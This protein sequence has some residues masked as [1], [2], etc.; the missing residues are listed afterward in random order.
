MLLPMRPRTRAVALAVAF[1]CV[2]LLSA[3][4]LAL[5][6][7]GYAG[8]RDAGPDAN[9]TSGDT[10]THPIGKHD[11]GSGHEAGRGDD[12]GRDATTTP[13][14]GHD[15]SMAM[16]D[17]FVDKDT[18]VVPH[19]AGHDAFVGPCD[20]DFV[21]AIPGT[22]TYMV[23][24]EAGVDTAVMQVN[25]GDLLVAIAYSGQGATTALSTAP[26]M[27]LTV[28]DTAGSVFHTG[29]LYQDSNHHQA[30]IQIS[31]A[32]V[33]IS[34]VDQVTATSVAYPGS[35]LE[36]WTGVFLQQ[37]SGVAA[38]DVATASS[39]QSAP[40]YTNLVTPGPVT[41]STACSLVVGAYTDGNVGGQDTD[42]GPGWRIR[43]TDIWCP[44]AACDNLP[45]PA[46]LGVAVNAEMITSQSSDNGWAAAQMVFRGA[47]T[48]ALPQP[49]SV[50]ITTAAQT[51]AAG[52]CSHAVGL[53]SMLGSTST[54]TANG[55]EATLSG[56]GMTFYVDPNCKYP[57]KTA[58]IGAGTDSQVFYFIPST[59]GS[60]TL[61]VAVNG[62]TLTQIETIN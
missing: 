50:V 55:F 54:I 12:A 5:S 13:D 35:N 26:N 40:A 44:A 23:M 31:Y 6:L 3:C 42:G 1:V 29:P 53:V 27:Q 43:S 8:A 10:G 41:T 49:D 46:G 59:T 52:S 25:A 14:G 30:A 37:Y 18:G 15:G 19:D 21:S 4:E 24:R 36:L 60:I 20:I 51:V 38:T 9:V 45:T 33:P 58:L 32:I 47:N 34:G 16:P 17:H 61:S 39:G 62:G 56:T 7:D 28:T 11:G 22:N 2:G 48:A 57:T